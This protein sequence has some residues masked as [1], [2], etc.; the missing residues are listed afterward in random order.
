MSQKSNSEGAKPPVLKYPKTV[1]F[2]VQHF[3]MMLYIS[4]LEKT[5]KKC[6]CC[7]QAGTFT[8]SKKYCVTVSEPAFLT[9]VDFG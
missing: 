6:E 9:D 4:V 5:I 3:D 7:I 2:G 1:T 8:F